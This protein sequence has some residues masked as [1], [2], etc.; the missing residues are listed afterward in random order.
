[1]SWGGGVIAQGIVVQGRLF[2]GN[3]MGVKVG[4]GVIVR[5]D[6]MGAIV[7]GA[8]VQ[9][10]LPLNPLRSRSDKH[11]RISIIKRMKLRNTVGKKIPTLVRIKRKLLI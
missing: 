1:M 11:T 10:E 2:R 5:G 6:F 7:W 4:G 9:G 3:C 8:I